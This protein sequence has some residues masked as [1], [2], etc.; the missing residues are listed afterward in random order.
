[1]SNIALWPSGPIHLLEQKS[2]VYPKKVIYSL[3]QKGKKLMPVLDALGKF[4][5]IA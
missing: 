5:E 4:G 2:N 1:M 3:T